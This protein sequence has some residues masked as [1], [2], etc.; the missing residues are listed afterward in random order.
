MRKLRVAI[1]TVSAVV[2][3]TVLVGGPASAADVT[4]EDGLRECVNAALGHAPEAAISVADAA[5]VQTLDCQD[6]TFTALTGMES[7]TAL[8][9][10]NISGGAATDLGPLRALP[11]LTSVTAENMH[12]SL[13][14]VPVG[15]TVET[16]VFAPDPLNAVNLHPPAGGAVTVDPST[17]DWTFNTPFAAGPGAPT[18]HWQTHGF[19][20]DANAIDYEFSGTIDQDAVY[21]APTVTTDP[22]DLAVLVGEPASFTAD[23]T[24]KHPGMTVRWQTSTNDGATWEN[25]D[26]ENGSMWT[27][28]ATALAQNGTEVRAVFT[29]AAGDTPSA[30]ATLTVTPI[31]ARP[32]VVTNPADLTVVVGG[33]ATFGAEATSPLP[34]MIAQW[35]TSTD[36]GA[37]W[38]DVDGEN[39]S[40]WTIPATTLAQDGTL[41][42]EA[43]TNALGTTYSSAATLTVTAAPAPPVVT[44]D[45]TDATVVEGR[46][47]TFSAAA[48][49]TDPD[50]TVRWQTSTDGTTWTDIA[51]ASDTILTIT[52]T[53]RAQDGSSVRAVFT[54]AVGSTETAPAVLTVLSAEPGFVTEPADQ[55]TTEGGNVEFTADF[56]SPVGDRPGFVWEYSIDGGATWEPVVLDGE[57]AAGE[58]RDA[59][60]APE[61]AEIEAAVGEATAAGATA[62]DAVAAV[63]DLYTVFLSIENIG[64]DMDGV[65]FRVTVSNSAGSLT[66]GPARLTVSATPAAPVAPA[67]PAI[68]ADPTPSPTATPALAKTGSTLAPVGAGA[69]ALVLGLVLLALRRRR[70]A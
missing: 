30:S 1:A 69:G 31:P 7:L 25:V 50:M 37:T 54:D 49:S 8:T 33:P 3:S 38:A 17:R 12:V 51:G 18:I 16:I 64:L 56:T 2:A 11:A 55:S 57:A 40:T 10:L 20:H 48:A 34:G 45:P 36:G 42:R 5:T 61:A 39:G 19:V 68:A 66:S 58:E 9:T 23:A 60:D 26:G 22:S 28:P 70:A 63:E 29:N 35:Q 4:F 53:T 14:T 65:D 43:F 67:A 15:T 32:T 62:D 52:G 24:S 44:T 41:V 59:G 21:V 27:I 47:A 6:G 13:A 46:P